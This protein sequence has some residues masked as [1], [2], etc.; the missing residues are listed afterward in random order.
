M[1]IPRLDLVNNNNENILHTFAKKQK[2]SDSFKTLAS[3]IAISANVNGQD[4]RGMSPIHLAI[5]HA[6]LDML[7]LLLE[8]RKWSS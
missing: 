2:L 1:V 3:K 6:N 8:H 4:E 5:H 7:K